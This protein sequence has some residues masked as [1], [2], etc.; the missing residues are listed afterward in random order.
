M[1]SAVVRGR[2]RYWLVRKLVSSD[3]TQTAGG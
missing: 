3:I 2:H 1:P